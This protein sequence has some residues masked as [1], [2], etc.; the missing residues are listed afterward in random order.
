MKFGTI[1]F[2][3]LNPLLISANKINKFK[4]FFKKSSKKNDKTRRKF[5]LTAFPHM[6]LSKKTLGTRMGKG[7]GKLNSW[8]TTL[9]GGIFFI[10][11][12]NLRYGRS[13]FFLKQ[14]KYRL[15]ISI[16]ILNSS[17]FFIKLPIKNKMFK[18][19]FKY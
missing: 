2:Y 14:L 16:K 13:I 5:W 6:P 3:L 17:L 1:G 9:H 7:K 4:L 8:F 19:N 10:E 15:N 12:K 18:I 11:F